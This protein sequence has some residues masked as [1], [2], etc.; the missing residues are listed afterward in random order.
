MGREDEKREIW[1]KMKRERRIK[2]VIVREKRG[3]ANRSG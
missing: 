3:D 1:Q 2:E